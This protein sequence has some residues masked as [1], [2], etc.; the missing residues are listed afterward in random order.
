MQNSGVFRPKNV[1]QNTSYLRQ[2]KNFVLYY[3]ILCNN[4]VNLLYCWKIQLS[5]PEQ[6]KLVMKNKGGPNPPPRFPSSLRDCC[7]VKLA[8]ILLELA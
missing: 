3:F 2:R 1:L 8:A 5:P 7:M 6:S 4:I